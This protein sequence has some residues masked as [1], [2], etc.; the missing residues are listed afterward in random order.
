M[1]DEE[2]AQLIAELRESLDKNDDDRIDIAEVMLSLCLTLNARFVASLSL[3]REQNK[4][5]PIYRHSG[6]FT[7]LAL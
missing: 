4:K 5:S 6:G 2:V 7:F 1:L 3:C